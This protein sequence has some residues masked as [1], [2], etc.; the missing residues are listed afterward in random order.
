MLR[1]IESRL[2]GP[3]ADRGRAAGD[4]GRH[5]SGAAE[6]AGH[7]GRAALPTTE[8]PRR[9]RAYNEV[10]EIRGPLDMTCLFELVQLVDRKDLR[11]PPLVPR[12]PVGLQRLRRP[13]RRDRRSRH[14]AAP[15]V[16]FVRAG[17]RFHRDGR[18]RS[19]GAGHQADA[20]PHQRRQPDRPRAGRGG[21][22]RQAR[23]RAGGAQGPLRRGEQHHLGAA[24]GAGRRARGV[25][26]HG[27]KTHCKLALVVRKEGKKVRRYVHLGT[28]NYNPNTALVY[29]DLGL[30]TADKVIADDVSAL[31]NFLTGYSQKHEWQKL[32][33]APSDLKRRTIELIDEQ[34]AAGPRRQA[35]ADLRQAQL[36]RRSPDDRGAVP[37]Q[38]GRRADRPDD[39]RHLLPAAGAAGHLGEHPRPQH[40][41]PLPGA[42]PHPGLRRGHQGAGVPQ[43]RRLDAAELRAPR[44]GDVP[45]RGGA[46][47]A[48]DR[49]RNHS[50]LSQRQ[51]PH[52]HA[53]RR[54]HLLR[55]ATSDDKPPHRSQA[56]CCAGGVARGSGDA[57]EERCRCR[58]TPSPSCGSPTASR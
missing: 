57:A 11:D 40:R 45:G 42:Q 32:V 18:P 49:R 12:P 37:R 9:R 25:R 27:L 23:H 48:A 31:F 3:A 22:E 21:R 16:R 35:V 7:R 6:D 53:P 4:L 26:L 41:R 10:Y 55:V 47:A 54:R 30:F 5:E 43:Q 58:S 50:H 56:S 14:P 34:A 17:A 36:A 38:P 29:T 46:A 2:A 39:P 51:L 28:G 52:A 24:A 8:L 20:L 1:S 44:R 13:V 15:S 33:V 19:E